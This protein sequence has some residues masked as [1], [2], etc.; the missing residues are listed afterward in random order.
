MKR[1]ADLVKAYLQER[2]WDGISP[3][4]V[5]AYSWA[6]AYLP[7]YLPVQP[8]ELQRMIGE[9]ELAHESKLD[10]RRAWRTF[11]NWANER[12]LR[13][14]ALPKGPRLRRLRTQR[15]TFS[16]RELESI[17]SACVGQRDQAMV[18][19][20]LDTGVRLGE[21]A[22]LT[23][24]GVGKGSVTVSGK[25]GMRTVPISQRT[26]EMLVGLGNIES[27]WVG[28]KGPLSYDGVHI[29]L[30][31]L[32]RRAGVSGKKQGPHTFR[33][34]FATEYLRAGGSL[35]TLQ[36]ILGHTSITVT[37]AYLHLV[38]DDLA[39]GH[40]TFSPLRLVLGREAR[41]EALL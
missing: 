31:R 6:L 25:T 24:A 35:W 30:R 3:K 23:W 27:L 12:G 14:I 4:T 18:A 29:A 5:E 8:S 20:L 10:I 28:R 33:H 17:W 19:L 21:L 1:T 26:Q 37:Q 13:Q 36:R 34:T 16:P 41:K 9:L 39:V 15:R 32:V 2:T 7:D 22:S 38:H 40:E 11:F